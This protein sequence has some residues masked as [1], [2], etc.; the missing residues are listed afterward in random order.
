M[1]PDDNSV[2]T[3]DSQPPARQPVPPAKRKRLQQCFEHGSKQMAQENYDYATEMFAQCVRGDPANEIYVDNYLANLKKKYNNN[4][5][6]SKLSQFKERGSRNAVKKALA[7]EQWDEAI[8]HGLKVLAVNPWDKHTLLAMA[9]AARKMADDEPEMLYLKSAWEAAPKDPDICE[10]A[11]D[12]LAERGEFDQAVAALRRVLEARP[13]SEEI[14]R[15]ISSLLV[16]KTIA[17]GEYGETDEAT[18]RSRRGPQQPQ[19]ILSPEEKLRRR[20]AQDSEDRSAYYDLAELLIAK[21]DYN[22]AAEVYAQALEALGE[23]TDLSERMED[24]ELRSLRQQ[25]TNAENKETRGQLLQDLWRKELE[26]Y[27][28]RSERYPN[29]LRFKYQLGIRYQRVGEY[30]EAIKQFQQARNDPRRK[31]IC[32]FYLGQCFQQIKQY[33]LAMSH[34]GTAIEEIPDRDADNK[35]ECLYKAGKLAMALKDKR[36]SMKHLTRLAEMDFTY[37]DVS[38]LL[39]KLGDMDDTD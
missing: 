35:K 14:N 29:D 22:Q 8:S 21:E 33:R 24:V 32:M 17:K 30:N 11:A 7:Q 26:V 27:K 34:Y 12:A 13:D 1:A 28:T 18:V 9:T 38:D 23:D 10:Q 5:T 16:E 3:E 2:P 6:G 19:R 39:D 15:K 25:I 37:K 4:K 31:G 36:T 20:I